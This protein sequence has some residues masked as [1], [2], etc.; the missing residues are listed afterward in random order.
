MSGLH[1]VGY[2]CFPNPQLPK[3]CEY[4]QHNSQRNRDLPLMLEA[5]EDM[6]IMLP[7]F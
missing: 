3:E 1:D 6:L 2:A 4:V 5:T 7:D